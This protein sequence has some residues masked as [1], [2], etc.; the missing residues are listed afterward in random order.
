MFAAMSKA[1]LE[2]QHQF[3]QEYLNPHKPQK[4]ENAQAPSHTASESEAASSSMSSSTQLPARRLARAP[5]PVSYAEHML[6]YRPV[7]PCA[8][9]GMMI[10]PATLVFSQAFLKHLP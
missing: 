8:G 3:V 9:P 10:T 4:A 1:A 2:Q 5:K 7:A 6:S